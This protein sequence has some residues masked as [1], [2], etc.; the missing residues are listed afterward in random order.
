MFKFAKRQQTHFAYLFWKET[1]VKK[2]KQK[3]VSKYWYTI[4][5]YFIQDGNDLKVEDD[6]GDSPNPRSGPFSG[7]TV[8]DTAN[9]NQLTGI[10]MFAK[11]YD[12]KNPIYSPFQGT[13]G[14]E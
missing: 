4:I 10:N 6:D 12:A 1:S 2:E 11:M 9:M 8:K 3:K 5:L 13:T 14:N 7:T